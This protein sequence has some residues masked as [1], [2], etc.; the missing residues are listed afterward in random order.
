MITVAEV[1]ASF[2]PAKHLWEEF[3]ML[4]G[5]SGWCPNPRPLF[6]SFTGG[7]KISPVMFSTPSKEIPGRENRQGNS[8]LYNTVRLHWPACG[9][10]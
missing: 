2:I 5:C 10:L 8:L 1:L 3:A 9:R 4:R 7:K 6:A